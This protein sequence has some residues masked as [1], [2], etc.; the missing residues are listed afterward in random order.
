MLRGHMMFP[1]REHQPPGETSHLAEHS[2]PRL[3]GFSLVFVRFPFLP[4]LPLWPHPLPLRSCSWG[5]L[6]CFKPLGAGHT[7]GSQHT[8]HL[9]GGSGTGH[10]WAQTTRYQRDTH[11]C[12]ETQPHTGSQAERSPELTLLDSEEEAGDFL[13]LAV[14]TSC[15]DSDYSPHSRKRGVTPRFTDEGTEGLSQGHPA[16]TGRT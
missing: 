3:F 12:R 5:L 15:T 10:G 14:T 2:P 6:T 1:E 9:F 11:K 13:S 16:N 7:S 4:P 8:S